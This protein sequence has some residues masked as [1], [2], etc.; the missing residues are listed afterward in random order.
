[1]NN[2]TKNLV[3]AFLGTASSGKTTGIK[4]LFDVDFGDISPIPGSTTD[5]KSEKNK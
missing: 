5:V 3:I 4:A 2:W 1:M